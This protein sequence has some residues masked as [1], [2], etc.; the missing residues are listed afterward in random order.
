MRRQE[1][2]GLALTA[3]HNGRR[4]LT[5]EQGLTGLQ[6]RPL[7]CRLHRLSLQRIG[8][9]LLVLLTHKVNLVRTAL[10]I[11]LYKRLVAPQTRFE[12]AY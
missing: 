1:L 12:G 3:E 9:Q 6:Q 7:R 5:L 11:R 8:P 10:E 2:L 4:I